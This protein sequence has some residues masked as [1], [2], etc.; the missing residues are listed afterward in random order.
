KIAENVLKT[1]ANAAIL[2]IQNAKGIGTFF[3]HNEAKA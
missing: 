3:R 1:S 2:E